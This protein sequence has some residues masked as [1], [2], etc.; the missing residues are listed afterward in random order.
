MAGPLGPG[1][2][3]GEQ[4]GGD[5]HA[6]GGG[7]EW[8][9]RTVE[10]FVVGAYV[11]GQVGKW[12][13]PGQD[14]LGV[15]R[16]QADRL[17]ERGCFALVA[18]CAGVVVC[19]LK[20]T[21][22]DGD[23]AEIVDQPGPAQM[24]LF[25]SGEPEV[26]ASLAGQA[27]DLVRVSAAP[28]RLEIGEVSQ[29]L[30]HGQAPV[31]GPLID[32]GP[33]V[34]RKH[35]GEGNRAITRVATGRWPGRGRPQPPADRS[36]CPTAG[37]PWRRRPRHRSVHARGRR[38]VPHAGSGPTGGSLLHA[39]GKLGCGRRTAHAGHVRR[40]AREDRTQGGP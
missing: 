40:T 14:A 19:V 15:V 32:R 29:C 23:L 33:R 35:L 39:G 38:P 17:S 22:R 21:V 30:A 12:A 31:V 13:D 2:G 9:A 1:I 3:G 7:P 4:P 36:S 24:I 8:I 16:V 6:L 28:N 26:R 27:G 10:A 37:G 34:T 11:C 18:A 25:G 20:Q 5:G